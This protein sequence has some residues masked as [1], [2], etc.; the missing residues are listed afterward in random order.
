MKKRKFVLGLVLGAAFFCCFSIKADAAAIEM[1]RL[2]NPNSGEH[3]YTKNTNEKNNLVNAGW[4]SEGIGWHAPESGR[5]VYRLYNPNAG[6][7]HYTLSAVER[8]NLVKAGW[9]YEGICWYSSEQ[10]K[11]PLYRAYNP[12]AKSG[13]HN[14]TVNTDEQK[15][16]VSLGWKDE[17]IGW[18][19][20]GEQGESTVIV[21]YADE[22]GASI[23][24]DTRDT[25]DVGVTKTFEAPRIAGYAAPEQGTQK[26]TFTNEN[27]TIKFVYQ[28]K[29][30]RVFTV[31]VQYKDE[32]NNE[33][34]NPLTEK[35]E[36]SDSYTAA[37]PEIEGYEISGSKSQEVTGIS[38][39]V[40]ITFIYSIGDPG[41]KAVDVED[42]A[43]FFISS[44]ISSSLV[45]EVADGSSKDGANVQLWTEA[46]VGQ[47]KFIIKSA[48][49]G[50]YRIENERTGKVLDA[51]GGSSKAGTNLQQNT[52][53]DL[54]GQ[55]FRF[56]D[57]DSGYTYIQS[58][59]GTYLD[60]ANGDNKNGANVQMFTL[61]KTNSQRFR[62][63]NLS[64]ANFVRATVVDKYQA[65]VTVFNPNGGNVNKIQFPTWSE[66]NG[67]DDVRWLEGS[68]N[69]DNSWSVL[70][71]SKAFRNGGKFIAHVY[72]WTSG[73]SNAMGLGTTEFSLEKPPLSA[74]QQ[75]ATSALNSAGWTLNGSFNWVVN[76]LSYRSVANPPSSQNF[77]DFFALDAFNQRTGNCYS[78]AAAFYHMAKLMGY[79]AY[80]IRGSVNLASGGAGPHGWV[81]IVIGGTTY[82]FD[83]ESRDNI[84]GYNG[85]QIR[86]GAAG[87]LKYS[88]YSRAPQGA[89]YQ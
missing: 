58:M 55:K 44:G 79:D 31:T 11:V 16:L 87:T 81:E 17:G 59:L 5:E 13:S 12:N 77:A 28:K 83:P 46:L 29:D 82:V 70:V 39:D 30:V 1:H 21:Q 57:A 61:N 48:G 54:P 41:L 84:R 65:R 36:E 42:G 10:E 14:Y 53:K 27:Q 76:N 66:T 86:Y 75:Q 9:E 8:D 71:N 40:T 49:S 24:P 80:L 19:G 38:K 88:N 78:Y 15:N 74:V 20:T 26:V 35:V 6:D 4:K 63:E 45:L 7:H 60:V 22:N 37:A 56:F 72:G 62:L 32:W 34:K 52:W 73:S 18:Y 64:Q 3:F 69:A 51:A 43:R 47:Q 68:K 89:D 25:Q 23:A 50:W 33:I 67:Q 85:Y 2:Y